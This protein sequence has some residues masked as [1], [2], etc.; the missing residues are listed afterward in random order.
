LISIGLL[1]DDFVVEAI[2]PWDL[3]ESM[4]EAEIELICNERGR[5]AQ[6]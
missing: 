1:S 3:R 4:T 2:V 6:K 5:N